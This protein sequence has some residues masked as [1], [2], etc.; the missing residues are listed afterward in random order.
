[1]EKPN[2]KYIEKLAGGDNS[3]KN[4]LIDIVKSEFPVEKKAYY[5][6]LKN[7]DQKK[8]EESVHKIKHKISILGL[9]KSYKIA[10]K[11]EH[12][13]REFNFER[14]KD[15]DKILIATSHYLKTI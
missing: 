15:F 10:N 7:K 9:E 5:E 2:L 14:V 3:L 6:N 4:K 11:F 12:D 8:T 1:M 13:L